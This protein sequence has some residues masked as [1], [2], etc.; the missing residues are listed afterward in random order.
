MT[1]ALNLLISIGGSPV[2]AL[3][4]FFIIG[5]LMMWWA[6]KRGRDAEIKERFH[7]YTQLNNL[8]GK[9]GVAIQCKLGIQLVAE[10]YT[11][12]YSMTEPLLDNMNK[13]PET[14]FKGDAIM[15]AYGTWLEAKKQI[16]A[17][18]PPEE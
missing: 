9:Y 8:V 11:G 13:I 5:I 15:E 1:A 18:A 12:E 2:D 7:K 4:M 17:K 3:L 10:H 16:D 6:Q 14:N